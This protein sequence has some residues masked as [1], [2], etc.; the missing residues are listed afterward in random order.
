MMEANSYYRL[1]CKLKLLTKQIKT[2]MCEEKQDK[3][4]GKFIALEEGIQCLID[5]FNN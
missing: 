2:S 3:L 4:R 1:I 5:D